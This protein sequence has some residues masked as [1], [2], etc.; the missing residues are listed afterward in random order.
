MRTL[1]LVFR[2]PSPAL[3]APPARPTA[4]CACP[5]VSSLQGRIALRVSLPPFFVYRCASITSERGTENRAW[6]TK[7]VSRLRNIGVCLVNEEQGMSSSAPCKCLQNC[8]FSQSD[9]S[10]LLDCCLRYDQRRCRETRAYK[11]SPQVRF[12]SF[13]YVH[14][15]KLPNVPRVMLHELCLNILHRK[16]YNFFRVYFRRLFR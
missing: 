13:Y 1:L 6:A 2:S 3:H 12:S 8:F 5:I 4:H 7:S 14:K 9:R 10:T 11:E 15:K 16:T